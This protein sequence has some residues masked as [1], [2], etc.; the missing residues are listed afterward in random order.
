M[1]I[2]AWL[3]SRSRR[4][5]VVTGLALLLNM[6]MLGIVHAWLHHVVPVRPTRFSSWVPKPVA[7]GDSREGWLSFL[8]P[9]GIYLCVEWPFHAA[10]ARRVEK[11][12]ADEAAEK[13]RRE[14]EELR[15]VEAESKRKEEAIRQHELLV[16]ERKK[17]AREIYKMIDDIFPLDPML[18]MDC[19][20]PQNDYE[21]GKLQLAE[22]EAKVKQI[23]SKAKK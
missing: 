9:Y 15:R 4:F 21:S 23:L 8:P 14:K 2:K 7:L 13:E 18:W 5:Y 3:K 1:D 22:F 12:W 6:W 10:S 17:K 19:A 20:V 16:E 11:Q